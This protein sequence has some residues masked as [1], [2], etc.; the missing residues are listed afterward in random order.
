MRTML[1]N[2]SG[3]MERGYM[4]GDVLLSIR[5]AECFCISEKPDKVL[6]T[7]FRGDPLNFLWTGFIRRYE[8]E[9]VD[10]WWTPSACKK[11]QF[12][13]ADMIRKTGQIQRKPFDIYKEIYPRLDGRVRQNALCLLERGLNGKNVIEYVYYGQ[14]EYVPYPD[15]TVFR[16]YLIDYLCNNDWFRASRDV[17]TVFV[18]P[19]ERCYRNRT[20]TL[21]FWEDVC[22]DLLSEGVRLIVNEPNHNFAP[23]LRHAEMLRT[24]LPFPELVEQ[25]AAMPLVMCGNTGIGWLAG[26]TNVPL[27][28]CEDPAMPMG[29]YAY[30]RNQHPSLKEVIRTPNSKQAVKCVLNYLERMRREND[31]A[32][33]MQSA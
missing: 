5:I 27:I 9:V 22:R 10:E 31:H 24:F 33:R 29:E 3:S 8:V 30:E 1:I 25:V 17:P 4:L 2:Y 14:E 32:N 15:F 19:Y 16:T 26:A 20:F 18:A 13:R 28:A 11:T 12:A 21:A 7:L 6:L 23:Q